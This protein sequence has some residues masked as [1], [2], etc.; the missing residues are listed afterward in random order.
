MTESRPQRLR[1]LFV[2]SFRD[3]FHDGLRQGAIVLAVILVA[4]IVSDWVIH[5][6]PTWSLRWITYALDVAIILL[7][8]RIARKPRSR[9]VRREGK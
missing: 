7:A 9:A 2:E 3:G 6:V 4:W 8:L 1:R 5:G